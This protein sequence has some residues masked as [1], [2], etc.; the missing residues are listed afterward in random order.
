MIVEIICVG[1][2]ILMGNIVNTNAAYLSE[3]CASL[4]LT[5]YYQSVV[6]DNPQRLEQLVIDAMQRSDILIFSGGLGPTQDDLTKETVAKAFGLSL[7]ED[8]TALS[9]LIQS[10]ERF[11]KPMTINNRKQ[12]LVPEG[13]IV[14]QNR[15]GTAPGI[16]IEGKLATAILLPGPPNELVPMFHEQ[17]VPYLK[18]RSDAT[19]FSKMIKIVGVG[20]SAVETMILD[21]IQGQTNP[22]I[23]TYAKTGEVHV[24]ITAFAKSQEL[25]MEFI[26]PLIDIMNER[27]TYHIFAYDEDT[28]LEQAIVLKLKKMNATISTAESCTGGLLAGRIINASGASA[29][30]NEGYIT[31]SNAAKIKNLFVSEASIKEYGA[32]SEVVAKEMANGCKLQTNSS[33]ALSTTGI[34][35]PEGGTKDK[36]VGT[37]CIGCSFEHKTVAKQ[38]QLSGTRE[39]IREVAVN[40]ALVYLWDIIG[41]HIN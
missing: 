7:V 26:Q 2:E 34:A 30:Y 13:S 23:A 12:A 40:R 35:G 1:T 36:P 31:Y 3:Q 17:V 25:A 20:E 19:L 16:I 41:G 37:I 5:M 18:T 6:G 32:V 29:V 9:L 22:T 28:T 38:F 4:G 8:A 21:L 33:F 24:R 27:F 10:F 39:K 15:A 11:Q 14:L